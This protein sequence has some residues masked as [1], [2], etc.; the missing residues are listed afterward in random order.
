[1]NT[2]AIEEFGF[3]CGWPIERLHEFPV[4]Q[5]N[6][7][8]AAIAHHFN[9][10]RIEELVAKDDD[11]FAR[12]RSR[13]FKRREDAR[14]FCRHVLGQP[15][16]QA[17]AQMR[18][19]L[20]QREMK[21]AREFRELLCRPIQYIA[22]EQATSGPQLDEVNPLRRIQCAPHLLEL[23][24]QQPPKHG[25]NIARGVKV[26]GLAEL[27]ARARVVAKLGLIE[28]HLHV[29]RERHW[30]VAAN[31]VRN[32]LAQ[33][34]FATSAALR[35]V[36]ADDHSLPSRSICWFSLRCCGVRTNISTR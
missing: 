10:K 7:Q 22:R 29:A 26:P 34:R 33:A 32:A 19:L 35:L 16:L 36:E 8:R 20:H 17:I 15:F 25:M 2:V 24:R 28:T 30:A 3:G 1:M 13:R 31:L 18:R 12:P 6:S 5:A 21:C 23:S 9:G 27:L 14:S 4:L 11:V